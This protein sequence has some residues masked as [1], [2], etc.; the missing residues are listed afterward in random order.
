[1]ST[2]SSPSVATAPRLGVRRLLGV[3]EYLGRALSLVWQTN[4]RLTVWLGL[5]GLVSGVL[6]VLVAYVGKLIIDGAILAA[7]T[8]GAGDRSAVMGLLALEL[9]LIALLLAAYRGLAVCEA[10]LRVQL[11]QRVTELILKKALTLEQADF[12]DPRIYDRLSRAK[13]HA[14]TRPLSLVRSALSTAQESITLTGYAILLGRFS[15]WLVVLLLVAALPAIYAEI[16]L[17]A[18]AFRLF[19]SQT[20]ETRRQDYYE[21]VLARED[22]AKEVKLFDLGSLFLGLHRKIFEQLYAQDRRLAWKRAGW[23][24]A[25]GLLGAA[26]LAV[27]YAWVAWSAIGRRISIG[28]MAM[29][30]VVLKQAESIVAMLLVSVASMYEDNLYL[31]TL[32]EL[33]DYPVTP[34]TGTATAG[35]TPGDGIRFEN[36]WFS[37]PGRSEPALSDVSFHVSAGKKLAIVGVN[38]AGKTTVIKLLTGLYAPSGGRVLVDGH[39]VREWDRDTLLQRMAVILQDFARYQLAAGHNIGLGDVRSFDDASR[40]EQAAR[41]ALVHDDIAALPSGY[42]TQLG[43]W[44]SDGQ[45]LSLGQWQ[46]VA[47]ARLFMRQD[48]DILIFDEPT[49]KLDPEAEAAFLERLRVLP[50][51][52]TA[53]VISHRFATARV[54]DEVLVLDR[55]RV[56]E[57]GHH[58]ELLASRGRYA[59]LFAAQA[60]GYQRSA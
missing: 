6:P 29:L 5:L 12:E 45:E 9:G 35:A 31:S 14:A 52:A 30:F 13:Q 59:E 47:L 38:G 18:D 20:P 7:G 58:D 21:T 41:G 22:F 32:E 19:R 44:F 17:N 42:E 49:S 16:R 51:D 33:L 15:L 28:E 57:R 10:L 37:Y 25:L 34:W 1:M 11:G 8:Q 24:L 2:S 39:D 56:I 40:W 48:A 43:R 55:G 26:A 53:I 46:R 23:G 60:E 4:R 54:A 3:L 36:V 27:S 50:R